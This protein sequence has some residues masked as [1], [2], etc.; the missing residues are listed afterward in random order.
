MGKSYITEAT[1]RA[2]FDR[3]RGDYCPVDCQ[4]GAQPPKV[5]AEYFQWLLDKLE[6]RRD[7]DAP[8]PVD[9]ER[10]VRRG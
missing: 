5:W 6:R 1:I 10:S 7:P 2:W 4:H 9:Y 3:H 8:V